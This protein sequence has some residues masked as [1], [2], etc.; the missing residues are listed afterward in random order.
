MI[1]K[2]YWRNKKMRNEGKPGEPIITRRELYKKIEDLEKENAELK[3]KL[4][5]AQTTLFVVVRNSI[6]ENREERGIPENMVDV[7]AVRTIQKMEDMID[8]PSAT[9]ARLEVEKALK[10]KGE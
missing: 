3:A 10:E 4:E 6:L 2:N 1:I 9:K 8:Y 5:K 7:I